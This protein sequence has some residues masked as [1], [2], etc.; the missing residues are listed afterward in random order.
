MQKRVYSIIAIGIALASIAVATFVVA[1][2][3]ARRKAQVAQ[4]TSPGQRAAKRRPAANRNTTSITGPARPADPN[5]GPQNLVDDALYTNEEFFGTQ[6]SVAR[7]YAVALERVDAL[8]ARYPKDPRLHLYAARLSERTGQFDRAITEMRG[9][10]DLRGRSRDALRRLAG[11]Y[12]HRA[13]FADEVRTLQELAR[14][15]AASERTPIYKRAAELVRTRSL[16]EFKPADFFAELV[17][18][19][20]SNIQPIKDFVEELQL[21]KQ[22]REALA[23][24]ASYQPK[25][26]SELAYFLRTRAQILETTGDRRGAEEVYAPVFD[27]NWPRALAGDYYELLRRFGRYRIVRRALQERVR[28]G[29]T[30]LDTV[31][32]LFGVFTYE[33]GYEQA[34]RLLL[35]L[36]DRRAG[37]KSSGAQPQTGAVASSSWNPR[38][39]ETV[40][41]MFASVGHY[42]QASR[43][44]YTFYL[45]GGLE[46]GTSS[47]E[48][49]LY[50][51][52]K[53]MLDAAGTPTRVGGGDLSFY[54]DV[55]E[56]DQNPGFLNGVLSLVLSGTSPSQEFAT[57]EKAA[58]GYFNRAFA[59]RIFTSFKQEY[60]QSTHLPEMY[61]GT[62]NVFASLLEHKLAIEAGREFQRLYPE[63]PRYAE[64]SLR[65]ADSYV[66]LKDRAN[67]RAVLAELL[68]RLA[69]NQPKG[70]PLV[71]VS[72]KHWSYGITPQIENLIDK[73][74]YN[75]EAYSDT[76]DPTDDKAA[77]DESEDSETE[78]EVTG[79]EPRPAENEA[80]R[81]PAYS[82]VLE[83][84]VS[85]LAAEDK[86]TETVAL[87]WG[88]IKKHPKEEGLYERFLRWLGQAQLIND[89]LKAYDSAIKQFDSNTWYHR[90]ARWYVRQKRGKDLT[91][92]SRQLIS[93]FDEDEITDYL[94]RFA[95]YGATAAGD[96]MNWDERLAFDLYSFART[97]FP[98]NV[99]FVRGMLSYQEK[100]DRAQWEKLS[101][102]YY[103]ADRSIREAYLAWLS[104]QGQLRE[105]YNKARSSGGAA[106]VSTYKIFGADA[107]L[108]I[109]H[110]DEA[111][112]AYRQLVALYPGE[113]QYAD[114]L[115]D[116]TRSFGQQSEK[117]F[118][119][120]ARA[121]AQMADIYPSDHS[122]RIKAGEVYAQLGDFKRAAEQWDKLIQIEPGERNTYLEVA[123]VFWDYYQFDQ[124]IRVFKELRNATGEQTIYAYRMG[125]VYEAKGSMD[126]AIAEYVN[127][128]SEPGEGRDTVAKRL[129]QLSKRTGLA[130]KIVAA[131]ERAR[132]A[133]PGDWR[134]IIGYANYQAEREQQADALAML[135][136]EVA[137]SSDVAFLESVRDLFRA[138]LR[139]EDEQQVITRLMAV[140]RDEREAM[141]YRLQLASFLERHGQVDAAIALIDKLAGD[142]PTNVGVVEES[143]QF[144][145]RAGLLDKSLDLYKRTLARALGTN[146]RSFALLLARRQVDANKL[147]DAEVT[148]RAFYNENRFDTEVFGE[149]ART[150]GAENKLNE[151]AAL[152][153]EAFK[154]AREAGLGGE[155][156]RA[157]VADLRAG[158]IRA[159]DSL[160]KYQEAV[161]Q[162]IE[163]INSFPEDTDRL[164]AAIEYAEQHSLIERLVGYYEKLS[165]ESNKN[166][167][168][169]L[170]LGRIYERRGNLAGA[171]EQYR[172][173][174]LNEP[175]RSELRFTLASVLTRQ[176][177]YDEAIATL[178]EGWT[179]AGRDP[180]WLIEVARIQVQQGQRDEAVKTIRQ[181]LA[182][183]KNATSEAQTNIAAQLAAWGLNGEAVRIYEQ[184]FAELPKKLESDEYVPSASFAGYVKA[185]IRSE[186]PAGAYQKLERLR[187]QFFAIAENTQEYKAKSIVEAID[188]A[189]RA[190]FGKGVIEYAAAD[191]APALASALQASIAKL[192][193]YSDAAALQRYLGIARGAALVEVEE[194]IQI[195]LKDAAFEARP[196]NSRTVTAQDTAYY[197]ELRATV[198]FYDRHAGYGRAAELLT[199][200]FRR[201][202]YKN[203]F[204]YQNQIATQYRLAGD[205]D[206][207]IEW[208]RAAYAGASGDLTTNYTDWVDRY[209]SLLHAS[210]Q[211]SELQR[212]ASTYSAY[213]LQLINF[214]V[215][216][217]EKLLAL[218]AISSAKQSQA[219]VQQ[220]SG[221]VGLFL[222]DTSPENE[223]FFK[224]ALD[225]KPIGQMLGRRIEGGRAL[226]GS[227]WFAG[228]RNYGYW[229][230]LV[231]REIDSRKFVAGEIEGHPS[232]ERA[233]LELAA[234]YLDRKNTTRASDHV[235]LASEL[236]PG[237]RD[238][239]VMRGAVA[240]ASRDRQ[241]ALDAWG[242]IMSGRVTIADAQAYLKVMADNGLLPEALPLLENFLVSF[243][244]RASRDRRAPDRI[245]AIKPLVREIAD[246]ASQDSKTAN[247][248]ATFF[249]NAINGMPGDMVIGRM[250]IEESLLPEN[251]L[252][253]IY[254]TMHQ[255]IS[256][257]ASSVLG[258][259]AYENGFYSGT[260]YVYPARELATWRKRLV[261]YLIRTRSFDEALLLIATIKREV[262]DL[263]IALEGDEE[264]STPASRYYWLPLASALIE[265]RGG[266]DAAK[267]ITE[268]RR[269]CGLEKT[270]GGR[271]KAEGSQDE[272]GLHERCSRAYVL[273]LAEGREQD[274]DAL[275]YDAYTRELRSRYSDDAV[276][277]GLA[278]IEARR[279]RGDEAS[280]LLKLLVARSTENAR[281]LQLAAET[282]ARTG[283][284]GDAIEFREQIARA[285]PDN[286][287]N[288]LEL[289]RA[290]AASG[291]AVDAVDRII[292]LIGE[293]ATPNTV[294]AQA[295]EVLGELVRADRSLASRAASSLDQ[296]GRSDAAVMLARAA[297]YE[298]ADNREEARAALASVN[299]G[300]LAAVAQMKIGLIAAAAGRD[301][302]AVT[303]FERALYLDADGEITEA[304]AF[305]APGPRAQ[306]IILYGKNGRDLAA[307][308][309]AE[310]EQSG[311]QLSI[312]SAV[313]RALSS[314][315][316]RREAQA[317]VS[318]EA[319]LEIT[320][321][322]TAG[323]KTLAEMNESIASR[324][325]G[326][327]LASLVESAAKLG[328]YDRAMAIE[329]LRAADAV[330]PEERTAIEKR[331][332]EIVAAEKARQLRLAMLTRIDRSNAA[333]S[334]YA[335]RVLETR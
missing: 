251:T 263:S 257:L 33:G 309:L 110:H 232:S 125:A 326:E 228:S 306:L 21:A 152:Y 14:A 324:L 145:W 270:E 54:R 9:Y 123:T 98:R 186:P 284:Y 269:Y 200:E 208:L 235:A 157:R 99:F 51:L 162:H 252:A 215:E 202:P 36:E 155:E 239:V 322:R 61:L 242:A 247:D 311:S 28:A 102:E 107:A 243:V 158:M 76:Y 170:V 288:K 140:A 335:T 222:K 15:S 199:A 213:Q 59:Y 296:R 331:L 90:L 316:G 26:P 183:K 250:L 40:A 19:D 272:T 249:H 295:A 156:T 111:L 175:Q 224:E 197:G 168:W 117:L 259:P 233:Q 48:E 45:V 188:R 143:A 182:A 194:Q 289:A 164:A 132:S 43:Y 230:G 165:K 71:A 315:A 216:K 227:D 24:L 50:R 166:Y 142:Y 120:S 47:R 234:Y 187:A 297:V 287:T 144:Y 260:E 82:S 64:V 133:N 44:L 203:R 192:T 1:Q 191:E 4:K 55:A 112:D 223:P 138:I 154:E 49:A 167:R 231:G 69:R 321:S 299:A 185:L 29:A 298:A 17:A 177:R 91:R 281:A 254:R 39:L 85:S 302:E 63:S 174:V 92:Y 305:R 161:D 118:E 294:R 52:F 319:S 60:A 236:A 137:R 282:A 273:L 176:R 261:D 195:R 105:R 100:N 327:L 94:L 30:D 190:D 7:P 300:P 127:V 240:L 32:R 245:E 3:S 217:N 268:L 84:Y 180:Q 325:V 238:V 317:N 221:E 184:V 56:V 333:G 149:L 211:R 41:G 62:V 286:A 280:R 283:R 290:I 172:I 278:E 35:E 189:M 95:G 122:Y 12:D 210:G 334:I 264:G 160:G 265:L 116:L 293:R 225:I 73:I 74:K 34:A 193:T 135:R 312:S 244:N 153:Q 292:S 6:A 58:A 72:P 277:A 255:R 146:R 204:D 329:R 79:V 87:F 70:I 307:I 214:L 104:K 303:S 119:E 308:R 83:R 241:G 96:A 103:F 332:A 10:A 66:A 37:K 141:M 13:R 226:V 18:A 97:R 163:I 267:A 38:E 78:S 218:D 314:G 229:L 323:L 16:K 68:D 134:L 205:R 237:E 67:E 279:G 256:D 179:L 220:R 31:A 169:Q 248:V 113:P 262:S 313:R 318:F 206:R 108:W 126:S 106:A 173:A 136:T 304:I 11:F 131:Y 159:L 129:A 285:N 93:V 276:L 114:R 20:P 181:A 8:L 301:A 27:P 42:D 86:K 101:T 75:A 147:A 121:F 81:G 258:T 5:R 115:A 328:E 150:L 53:V 207:E 25:F 77:T 274:A 253:G 57:E 201:D 330:K 212:L 171:A 209:L 109:S 46:P 151:L 23:V 80:R 88:E 178:R 266:R 219:W 22:Y 148:L 139:P 65:I 128:L 275:L 196:K 246:R 124:A 310:G 320:R 291:R 2:K 198:A 130:E 89:Q 271:Q